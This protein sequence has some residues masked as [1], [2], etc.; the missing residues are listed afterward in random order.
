MM[1]GMIVK[2][3]ITKGMIIMLTGNQEYVTANHAMDIGKKN[4]YINIIEI[5][6]FYITF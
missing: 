2:D 4:S 3:T 5:L 6:F 1:E